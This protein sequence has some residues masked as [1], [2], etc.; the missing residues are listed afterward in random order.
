MINYHMYWIWFSPVITFPGAWVFI[1]ILLQLGLH[2]RNTGLFIS[3]AHKDEIITPMLVCA[4]F[5]TPVATL[6]SVSAACLLFS[7]NPLSG[8]TKPLYHANTGSH[9]Q[10]S[11]KTHYYQGRQNK[12]FPCMSGFLLHLN[13]KQIRVR[14]LLPMRSMC[15]DAR[16]GGEPTLHIREVLLWVEPCILC[17]S[18]C[19]DQMRGD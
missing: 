10:Q 13:R 5:N 12:P 9:I 3:G 17:I 16:C 6:L 19:N 8:L 2:K 14:R 11:P 7:N 4:K 1:M 18:G 15:L